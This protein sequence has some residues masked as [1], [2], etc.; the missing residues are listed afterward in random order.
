MAKKMYATVAYIDSTT[1]HWDVGW[2]VS[3]RYTSEQ[4][5]E[6]VKRLYVRATQNNVELLEITVLTEDGEEKWRGLL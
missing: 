2:H 3:K 5:W 6:Y 1:A 4:L